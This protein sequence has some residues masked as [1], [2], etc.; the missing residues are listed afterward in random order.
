MNPS[1]QKILIYRLGS[2]GDTIIALP[3]FNRIKECFPEADITL[4]TNIPVASKAAPLEAVLGS[5]YFFDRT[6]AYPIHTRNPKTIFKL[7]RDIRRLEIDLVV[8]ICAQRSQDSFKRDKAFFRL[9]GISNF[10]GFKFYTDEV[11]TYV[12][13][14]SGEQEWEAKFLQRKLGDLGDFDLNDDKYWDLHLTTQELNLANDAIAEIKD[15]PIIALSPGTKM[16]VK[17]WGENAWIQLITNLPSKYKNY[18]IAVIG[19]VEEADL[20]DRLIEKWS[21]KAINFCG[22][23]SPRVSAAILKHTDLFIGH[24]SGPMHLAAAVGVPCVSVFSCINQPRRWFPR[25]M[26]NVILFPDTECAKNGLNQCSNPNGYCVQTIAPELVL[27]GIERILQKST[28][29]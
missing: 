16:E 20:A 11:Y 21:G 23:T 8:N 10:L 9:A 15:N 5:E 1:P 28:V 2:L 3:C 29:S 27:D 7:L 12:N 25:G 22:K 4:L 19:S 26:H 14:L 24:D 13:P 18:T 6:L 17:D